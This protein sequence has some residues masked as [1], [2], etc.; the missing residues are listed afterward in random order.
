MMTENTPPLPE[1][2][3]E[4]IAEIEKEAERK[5]P[6]KTYPGIRIASGIRRQH[7]GF[8]MGMS[9]ERRRSKQREALT[10][11]PYQLCPKCHGQGWVSKP[12]CVAGDVME[13]SSSA[14]SFVCD[15]CN[16]AKIIKQAV[17]SL[18]G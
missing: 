6:I 7:E 12:P 11:V 5:Y 16:G 10:T 8:I 17:E 3:S 14:T 1:L 15:V 18:P 2:N 4:D 13:W 9:I